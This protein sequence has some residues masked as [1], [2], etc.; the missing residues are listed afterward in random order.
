[1]FLAQACAHSLAG[2]PA[3]EKY[4]QKVV[5]FQNGDYISVKE[6]EHVYIAMGGRNGDTAVTMPCYCE[7][8]MYYKHGK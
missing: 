7:A 4:I 3:G 6:G 8:I 5:M 1:M 2:G